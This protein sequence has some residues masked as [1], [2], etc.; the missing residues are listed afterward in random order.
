MSSRSALSVIVA[1]LFLIGSFEPL[2]NRLIEMR[3][4]L[5]DRAPTGQVAI[6]EIDAK[7][8]SV[9]STWPWSRRYHAQLIKRLGDAGVAMTA[10]DV[11]FSARSDP[12]QRRRPLSRP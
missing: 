10:F 1:A 9:I 4:A 5:L 12:A 11:D 2:E 6:V 8:L 3:A 7:S